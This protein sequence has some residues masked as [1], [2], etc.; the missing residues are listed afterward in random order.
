MSRSTRL[1]AGRAAWLAAGLLVAVAAT[2]T[3]RTDEEL[4]TPLQPGTEINTTEDEVLAPSAG[5]LA[6]AEYAGTPQNFALEI[7]F[8][9]YLPDVDTEFSGGESPYADTFGDDLLLL[10]LLQFDWE[11]LRIPGGTLA[12][13]VSA[14]FMQAVGPAKTPD[15]R[16]S[17]ED[18][19]LNVVPAYW[20]AGYRFDLFAER[21]DVPLVPFFKAGIATY[22][23]WVLNA[24]GTAQW[25]WT[26]GWFL[27]PGLAL[28]LDFFEPGTARSFDSSLGVNHS[29]LT[30]E[31]LY[32]SVDGFGRGKSMILSDLT[33]TAG[34]AFE[35]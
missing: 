2:S 23:W 33:F 34:L 6:D 8:G 17:G 28:Q 4:L 5:A 15:G 22:W 25:G 26:P 21:W 10:S 31:L 14:G 12:V 20:T 19:V 30:I 32:A 9:P 27:S 24:A 16:E 11:Y 18:T 3:A 7:R 29:Y 13:G 35:F 1:A